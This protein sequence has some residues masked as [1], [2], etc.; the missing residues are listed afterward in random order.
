MA[1][2]RVHLDFLVRKGHLLPS[3]STIFPR[4]GP[5]MAKNA[6]EYA[7][8]ASSRRKPKTGPNPGLGGSYPNLRVPIP[9][10]TPHF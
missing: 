8:F 1:T 2:L 10:A 7:H 6:K 3:T 9:L 4:N 5:K